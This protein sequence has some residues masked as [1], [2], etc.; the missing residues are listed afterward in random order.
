MSI[1]A[2]SYSRLTCWEK[3]PLQFKFRYIDK[4]PDAKSPAMQRGIDIHKDAENF[5]KGAVEKL[6]APLV[7]F[8]GLFA[9]LKALNPAVEQQWAFTRGWRPTG[10][11]AK[12]AWVRAI[13]D[14]AVVYDDRTADV[15]DFKTGKKY[16]DYSDQLE[17]FSLATMSNYTSVSEVTA[18]LWYLDM[19][20]HLGGEEKETFKRKDLPSLK[21]KWESRALRMLGDSFYPARP[22]DGCRWCPWSRSRGGP[23]KFG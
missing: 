11:F 12:D 4:L 9:E 1:A 21:E 5:L 23:C 18:R 22:N 14:A 17:L 20:P 3:C 8:D 13:L 15:I 16:E 6:P 2:W 19:S 10:W 7:K